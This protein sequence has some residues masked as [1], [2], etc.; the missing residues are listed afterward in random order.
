MGRPG[1]AGI[2]TRVEIGLR[3][4]TSLHGARWPN[5]W[6]DRFGLSWQ[7]IPRGLTDRL[8]SPHPERS[9]RA[10]RA[11]LRMEKLELERVRRPWEG[12]P[13]PF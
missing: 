7:V 5:P 4:S 3:S 9:E 11:I 10:M 13:L 12:Q 2:D 6:Q 1:A 8:A